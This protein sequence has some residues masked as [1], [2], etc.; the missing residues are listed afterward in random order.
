MTR[1]A[2][3][4]LHEPQLGGASTAVLWALGELEQRGWRFRFWTPGPG[5]T[6]D[7]LRARGYSVEG[8]QRPLR[9]SWSAL[10]EPPGR[11]T[12]LRAVAPYLHRFRRVVA[13]TA[14]DLV[15]ANTILTLPEALIARTTGAPTLLHVHEMLSSDRRGLVA[16]RLARLVDGVVA[17][18]EVSAAPLRRQGV[19]TGVVRPGISPRAPTTPRPPADRLVVGSL[20]TVCR[21]KGSDVFVEAAAAVLRERSDVEF[22]MVGPPASGPEEGWARAL[23]ARAR[24]A[25]IDW[26][27]QAEPFSTIPGWDLLVLPTRRDPFPLVVLE[28]MAAGVPVIAS[29]V[30]GVVEQVDPDSGILVEPGDAGALRAAIVS[31]LDDPGR[32]AA[33]ARA[34]MARVAE[35]FTPDRQAEQ[36]ARAYRDALGAAERRRRQSM[37]AHA[38][39]RYGGER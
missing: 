20:A 34:A 15:H 6:A 28:A 11:W 22:R 1:T 25:G 9:Y 10:G 18:S 8:E 17:D 7:L 4:V 3:V 37:G 21:R 26:R 29:R 12:R 30:D 19:P 32:R 33:M 36:L 23:I 14:P 5:P 2:L 35:H 31:L 39:R 16:A 38:Y 24:A 13:R 27:G